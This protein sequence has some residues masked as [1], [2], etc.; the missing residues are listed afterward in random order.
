MSRTP[1]DRP[2]AF[3]PHDARQAGFATP[4]FLPMLVLLSMIGLLLSGCGSSGGEQSSFSKLMPWERSVAQNPATE[5]PRAI[6]PN[7]YGTANPYG[8][9][10]GVQSAANR[11]LGA[12]QSMPV[13]APYGNG[14][15]TAPYPSAETLSNH[16]TTYVGGAPTQD[17]AM[18][19]AQP[20]GTS[21]YDTPYYGQAYPQQQNPQAAAAPAIK[22]GI[23][24]PLSGRH[25]DL[26]QSMLQAAQLALFDMN[27][28]NLELIP[29]DTKGT[30]DGAKK[31]AQDAVSG[32][33]QL[34]LG[35]VFA[36]SVR[37]AKPIIEQAGLV[38]LGFS[39]D[40]RVAGGNTFIMGVLPFAQSERI[41][42]Y[43]AKQSK[44][45]I[46]II[47]PDNDYGQAVV[48]AFQTRAAA[49]GVQ[50]TNV[51][52]FNPDSPNLTKD[53]MAFA[54]YETRTSAVEAEKKRLAAALSANP[55]DIATAERLRT[56]ENAMTDGNAPYDAIFVPVGGDQGKALMNLLAYYDL[57]PDKVQYLGTGLWDDAAI[58]AEPSMQGAW[59]AA[60]SPQLRAEF[61]TS[62]QNTYSQQP[63]RLVSIAYD[64]TAL[65]TVLARQGLSYG[66]QP[67]F[68]RQAVT[69]PNGFAGIDG[70]FRFRPDGIIQR[71]LAVHRIANGRS[72]VIEAAPTTFQPSGY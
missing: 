16:P 25:K 42:E 33:A 28:T 62:Y 38:M 47:A 22:V 37:A 69:N 46:G 61:E 29:R 60:P 9:E 54:Q 4:L 11:T 20:Y 65:A 71:G 7:A 27:Y 59:Y 49:L 58:Q 24:L 21:G 52:R 41:A 2:Q 3:M 64:A 67:D 45:R 18:P 17:G 51:T 30:P 40:W 1:I 66:T 32:G 44:R 34:I 39:T 19:Q 48:S 26:G 5:T 70:I 6:D 8:T 53:V 55:N 12:V 63:P 10:G 43:A 68:S 72:T 23:L 31:A 56:L 13:G 50:I 14:Q 35:P 15:Y 36:D 57:G